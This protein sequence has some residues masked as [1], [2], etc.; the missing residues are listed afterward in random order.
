[1]YTAREI[2]DLDVRTLA[3]SH[4]DCGVCKKP[5]MGGHADDVREI[6]DEVV[7][8]DCYFLELSDVVEKHPV[9]T[10]RSHRSSAR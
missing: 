7:H 4:G 3:R 2:L 10:P 6:G 8:E 5:V 9:G 1:M